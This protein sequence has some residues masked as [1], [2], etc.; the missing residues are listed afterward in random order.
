MNLKFE[1]EVYEGLSKIE[2]DTKKRILSEIFDL[3]K[4]PTPENSY[5]IELLDCS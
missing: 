1:D 5:V 3:E 4:D 2:L